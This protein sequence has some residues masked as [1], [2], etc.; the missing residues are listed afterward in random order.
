MKSYLSVIALLLMLGTPLMSSCAKEQEH[1]EKGVIEQQ[2]DKVA[3]EAV[4]MIKT[5]LDQAKKAAEQAQ[6]HEQQLDKQLE[7]QE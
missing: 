1:K 5:P 4:N 6:G 7:K 3:Q 2:T